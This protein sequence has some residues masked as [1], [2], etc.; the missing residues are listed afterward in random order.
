LTAVSTQDQEGNA[1]ATTA[2]LGNPFFVK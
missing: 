2:S 1:T